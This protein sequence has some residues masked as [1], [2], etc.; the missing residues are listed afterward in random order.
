MC[1]CVSGKDTVLQTKQ[2]G[3][4]LRSSCNSAPLLQQQQQRLLFLFIIYPKDKINTFTFM[5][6]SLSQPVGA[7]GSH[8]ERRFWSHMRVDKTSHLAVT[9]NGS[10]SSNIAEKRPT[11]CCKCIS[12]QINANFELFLFLSP[13][14]FLSVSFSP[15]NLS[16]VAAAAACCL[17]FIIKLSWVGHLAQFGSSGSSSRASASHQ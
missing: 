16:Q 17:C 5:Y 3:F 11:N 4:R 6:A 13:S 10:S 14:S 9:S 1:V 12:M 2:T 7:P 15:C 8:F